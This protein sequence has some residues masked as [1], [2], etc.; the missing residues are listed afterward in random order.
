MTVQT[1]W[2]KVLV[3]LQ[4]GITNDGS[5]GTNRVIKTVARAAY[6]FRNA[7]NQRLHT[8]CATTRRARGH[9]DPR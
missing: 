3:F 8:R 7:A 2:P 4:T 1:W 5:E 6:G 9:L